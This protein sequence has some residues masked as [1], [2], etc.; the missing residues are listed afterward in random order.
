MFAPLATSNS[1]ELSN[2]RLECFN[3]ELNGEY[4]LSQHDLR[5]NTTYDKPHWPQPVLG[6]EECSSVFDGDGSQGTL[7]KFDFDF[8]AH[9]QGIDPSIMGIMEQPTLSPEQTPLSTLF[10]IG[11]HRGQGSLL[12]KICAGNAESPPTVTPNES[13]FTCSQSGAAF[14]G[15]LVFSQHVISTGDKPFYDVDNL[16]TDSPHVPS[17][18]SWFSKNMWIDPDAAG[19]IPDPGASTEKRPKGSIVTSVLTAHAC[20]AGSE[21][22]PPRF[23]R[24]LDSKPQEHGYITHDE[25]HFAVE[26][27]YTCYAGE[28]CV[29][30]L[31]AQDFHMD[32]NGCSNPDPMCRTAEAWNY[33]SLNPETPDK[34]PDTAGVGK[35]RGLNERNT[36][37]DRTTSCH[38]DDYPGPADAKFQSCDV[39]Q[40]DLAPGWYDFTE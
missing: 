7:F 5:L 8:G 2:R 24:S 17:Q 37:I 6:S 9:P 14:T 20:F 19:E 22:Q 21:N 3:G 29:L 13:P 26:T 12:N 36:L 10:G 38:S 23:V 11:G 33:P 35:W 30:P 16:A 40:I 18:V 4:N 15:N 34:W 1:P 31:Y 27:E 25:Q 39:V 32:L 28:E